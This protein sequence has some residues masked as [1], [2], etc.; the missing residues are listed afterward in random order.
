MT[1]NR[2]LVWIAFAHITSHAHKFDHTI[3]CTQ[4]QRQ[5]I[6][7]NLCQLS[8]VFVLVSRTILFLVFHKARER[9]QSQWQISRFERIV[10]RL[11]PIRILMVSYRQFR[12]FIWHQL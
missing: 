3:M 7:P 9:A 5:I 1:S 11:Y 12:L 4:S 6:T 2:R 8:L 10:T